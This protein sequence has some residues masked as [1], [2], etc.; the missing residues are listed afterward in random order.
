MAC[1]FVNVKVFK[2]IISFAVDA[3]PPRTVTTRL[4]CS[5]SSVKNLMI[6][7][8]LTYNQI[9]PI[10]QKRMMV[11]F[12][13]W[14][15]RFAKCLFGHYDRFAHSAISLL[16]MSWHP[17]KGIFSSKCLS[18]YSHFRPHTK[19]PISRWC[20]QWF[21]SLLPLLSA[22]V[23]QKNI[24]ASHLS[25]YYQKVPFKSKVFWLPELIS[26]VGDKVGKTHVYP[27]SS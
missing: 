23:K 27:I 21:E 14:W 9:G 7:I 24:I 17:N 25:L 11:N 12:R 6:A 26:Q 1:R 8:V 15:Q 4:V 22:C 18:V 16:R 3:F 19:R 20:E 2:V 10:T 13:F 5:I